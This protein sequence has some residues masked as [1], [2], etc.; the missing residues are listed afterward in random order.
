MIK[1]GLRTLIVLSF[2]AAPGATWATA[3]TP[4]NGPQDGTPAWLQH[5]YDLT[6]LSASG[7][8][9]QTVGIL[10][11]AP[12]DPN[13]STELSTYRAKYNLSPCSEA[14]G[15]LAITE[16]TGTC[17]SNDCVGYANQGSWN[18][19]EALDVEAVSAICP[20]CH[21]VV[22]GDINDPIAAA[23]E[24]EAMGATTLSASFL[25]SDFSDIPQALGT[26]VPLVAAD[27]DSGITR[28]HGNGG[29]GWPAG[30]TDVSAAGGTSLTDNPS[31]PRGVDETAWTSNTA[32]TDGVTVRDN[33][34]SSG[35]G[36]NTLAPVPSYQ[37]G[38]AT[39]CSGRAYGDI[40]ALGA[41]EFETYQ[42]GSW[43]LQGGTS[44][45]AP[46]IAAYYALLQSK[47]QIGM[48]SPAWAYQNVP[49]LN[50]MDHQASG[51]HVQ[52]GNGSISGDVVASAPAIGAEGT[53]V[54]D[55]PS[56]VIVSGGVYSN[57]EATHVYLEYGESNFS[58]RTKTLTLE[59]GY[60]ARGVAF[61]LSNLAQGS[62]YEY[63]IVASNAS[64]TVYGLPQTF[65]S[66]YLTQVTNLSVREVP[67]NGLMVLKVAFKVKD[68]LAGRRYRLELLS[69][70]RS[71]G[72]TDGITYFR[73]NGSYHQTIAYT[74]VGNGHMVAVV[75]T[76]KDQRVMVG[77]VLLHR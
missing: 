58:S 6:A 59:G 23:K 76:L 42:T 31:A 72:T 36:C 17:S 51:W 68:A 32:T 14:N 73:S 37:A 7:G 35:G 24:L 45:S 56:G 47:K 49:A 1:Q 20:N 22:M 30:A 75:S 2:L 63:R 12:V 74:G 40:S 50:P 19:E 48:V 18:L 53:V 70:T 64:G 54:A 39:N 61:R 15:C 66:P 60:G 62:N 5:A 3:T 46:I 44:L 16:M 65:V 41:G 33:F 71:N 38:L 26:T 9:G 69:S 13:L 67:A 57:R 10:E 29:G 52:S 4:Y 8:S 28:S 27:G 55:A 25:G 21:I 11:L 34:S 43:T 77:H